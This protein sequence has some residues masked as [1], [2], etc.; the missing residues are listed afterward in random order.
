MS[1]S[2]TDPADS[3]DEWCFVLCSPAALVGQD[4]EDAFVPIAR[5]EPVFDRPYLLDCGSRVGLAELLSC[6]KSPYLHQ[7]GS[8]IWV[9]AGQQ[10]SG[11][12]TAQ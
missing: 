5:R 11:D 6:V 4:F 9:R 1:T 7:R 8:S 12:E 10:K 2:F 3:L